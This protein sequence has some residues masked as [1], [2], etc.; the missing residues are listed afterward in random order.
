MKRLGLP[1][2]AVA[3]LGVGILLGV[4]GR[5]WMDAARGTAST[6][7]ATTAGR[8]NAVA[9]A[10]ALQTAT[11]TPR[12]TATPAPPRDLVLEFTEAELTEQLQVLLVGQP[13]GATPIGDATI[14]SVWVAF[15]DGE[16]QVGGGASVG[17]LSGPFVVTGRI[18]P[19]EAGR[20][21]LTLTSAQVSGFMIPDGIR[22]GLGDLLQQQLDQLFAQGTM[23]VRTIEMADGR[24]RITATP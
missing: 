9:A 11:P 15:R 2:A 1:L 22:A 5:A 19:N 20:P 10:A 18:A 12:P 13:L 24:M 3:I 14:R 23:R 21:I 17:P 8:P 4:N 6:P 7:T 16:M